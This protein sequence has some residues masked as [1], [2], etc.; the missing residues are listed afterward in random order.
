MAK[1]NKNGAF[2]YSLP[3]EVYFDEKIKLYIPIWSDEQMDAME[4]GIIFEE[5]PQSTLKEIYQREKG[6]KQPMSKKEKPTFEGMNMDAMQYDVMAQFKNNETVEQPQE[7]NNVVASNEPKQKIDNTGSI[8]ITC[9]MEQMRVLKIFA[10]LKHE[11]IKNIILDAL[12]LYYEQPQNKK[13]FE[14]AKDDLNEIY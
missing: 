11:T 14:K 5:I 2:V 6:A 13:A 9:T 7:Q 8:K 3:N 4:K 12:A 10:S 1:N